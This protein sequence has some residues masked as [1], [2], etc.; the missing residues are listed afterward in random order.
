MKPFEQA[1]FRFGDFL[2]VPGEVCCCRA[3]KPIALTGKAFDLLVTLVR[4]RRPPADQRRA[5]AGGLARRGGRGG[6]PQRQRLGAAQGARCGAHGRMDRDRAAAG[7][8]LQ[9]RGRG[10]RS[11]PRCHAAAPVEAPL[12]RSRRRTRPRAVVPPASFRGAA[13]PCSPACRRRRLPSSAG[14]P[15]LGRRLPYSPSRCCPSPSTGA[16]TPISPMASSKA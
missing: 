11:S 2:L 4:Q 13:S 6:E 15:W 3:G 12:R 16:R 7:L 5:A 8:P 1:V 10:R 14:A 9:R